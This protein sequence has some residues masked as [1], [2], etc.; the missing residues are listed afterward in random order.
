MKSFAVS[1]CG[2]PEAVFEGQTAQEAAGEYFRSLG[3]F[4]NV[5]EFELIPGETDAYGRPKN[6]GGWIAKDVTPVKQEAPKPKA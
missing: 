2:Y 1:F 6:N 4:N 5:P 3:M